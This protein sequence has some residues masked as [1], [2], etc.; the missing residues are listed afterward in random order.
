MFIFKKIFNKNCCNIHKFSLQNYSFPRDRRERIRS[1]P[2][3]STA[4]VQHSDSTATAFS[5]GQM[6]AAGTEYP[7][8]MVGRK[9]LQ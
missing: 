3:A 7:M 4:G 9:L 2:A 5:A 6:A 8:F 1:A